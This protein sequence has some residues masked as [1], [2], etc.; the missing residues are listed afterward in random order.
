MS[1]QIPLKYGACKPFKERES[2]VVERVR[3]EREFLRFF[4][5][6][7]K[8]V[9]QGRKTPFCGSPRADELRL[10]RFDTFCAGKCFPKKNGVSSFFFCGASATLDPV[11]AL[12][13]PLS[14]FRHRQTRFALGW[15]KRL[16]LIEQGKNMIRVKNGTQM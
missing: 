7:V 5:K 14:L 11:R 8:K 12:F 3:S 9:V 10:A 16:H 2:A 4:Q 1:Y 6:T 13:A 15:G